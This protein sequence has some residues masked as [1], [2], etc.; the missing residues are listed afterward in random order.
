MLLLLVVLLQKRPGRRIL[1]ALCRSDRSARALPRPYAPLQQV[2]SSFRRGAD[3]V[4]AS[5]S[6]AAPRGS[7]PA[8]RGRSHK[9]ATQNVKTLTTPVRCAAPRAELATTRKAMAAEDL[10][11]AKP[12]GTLRLCV[13]AVFL[14]WALGPRRSR[15]PCCGTRKRLCTPIN[16]VFGRAGACLSSV[17]WPATRSDLFPVALCNSVGGP[18]QGAP[19]HSR[20]HTVRL[21]RTPSVVNRRLL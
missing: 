1:V 15:W 16:V 5:R 6:H 2:Q 14:C 3:A 12:P 4:D 7:M 21:R 9:Q 20:R 11:D 18:V 13:R 19:A 17:L 10:A 8:R